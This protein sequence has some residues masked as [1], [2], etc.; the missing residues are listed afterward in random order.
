MITQPNIVLVTIDSLRAD[1]CGY[2]NDHRDATPN[3]TSMAETGT[4]Y[5]RAIAPGPST[6]ESMPATFTGQYPIGGVRGEELDLAQ[7]QERI[8]R[9]MQARDPLARRLARHGYTTGAFTPNPFTSRHFGYD[10]GFDHFQDFMGAERETIGLYERVFDGFLDG[11]TPASI[12][13]ILLNVWQREE[14]FKP[15]E[16]YFDALVDWT[17]SADRPYFLWVFLMDAHNPYLSPPPYRSQSRLAQFHANYRFWRESHE[18]P[19]APAVHDRLVTAYTDAVRYADACLDALETA[20]APD[21]PIFVVHGDH[22]EAFGEHGTYGHEPYLYPEN[23]HV[24]LVVSGTSQG[25][26]ADPVSLRQLPALI[27]DLAT[28]GQPGRCARPYAVT[29]TEQGDRTAV[30]T[31]S[32]QYVHSGTVSSTTTGDAGSPKI[33]IALQRSE[34]FHREKQRIACAAAEVTDR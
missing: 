27:T 15:W 31:R 3:L 30:Y 29:R 5:G 17:S 1:Y 33:E 9:H 18:T 8:V 28:G 2:I 11:S 14:V 4:A 21:D 20:L 24:P 23:V 13:R 12:A 22:G 25:L 34:A 6:P 16:S 26:I 7:Y 19:F 10:R 32:A